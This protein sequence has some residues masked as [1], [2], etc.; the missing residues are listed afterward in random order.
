MK[1]FPLDAV[2]RWMQ[3]VIVHPGGVRA[4]LEAEA[5]QKHLS[6][7]ADDVEQLVPSSASQTSIERLA[8][9]ANAYYAR[10]IE[11]LESEFPVFRQTVG[12]EAFAE[13]AADYLQR[14]PSQ[15]YSLGHLGDNFPSYLAET[16]PQS[17]RPGD[18]PGWVDFLVELAGME[19]VFSDVFDGPGVENQT[20]LQEA[21][22]RA[23]DPAQ[24]AHARLKF[25]PCFRLLYFSFPLND[26]YTAARRNEQPSMPEARGSWLAVTRRDFVVR[27]YELKHSQFVLLTELESGGSVG[28]AIAAAA[29][30]DP[31]DI[32]QFSS[33][34]REW[35]AEWTAAPFFATLN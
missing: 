28:D 34:L 18:A 23:I 25:V 9:Y 1:E 32:A 3:S 17:E 33:D 10:L 30:L 14:Y 15:S 24:W 2:Q 12:E 31:A 6:L 7:F 5:T 26:F 29:A 4:G 16:K 22:L 13:F 11:C 8:V 20:Q 21:D 35:F 19:R 27:R